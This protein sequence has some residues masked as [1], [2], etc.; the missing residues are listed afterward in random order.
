MSLDLDLKMQIILL[1]FAFYILI[2]SV[3]EIPCVCQYIG[4]FTLKK[5]PR[6][7][8][9]EFLHQAQFVLFVPEQ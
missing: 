4:L 1:V 2:L 7:P 9:E 3:F 6:S 8:A 5:E